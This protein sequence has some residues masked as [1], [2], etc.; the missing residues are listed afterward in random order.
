M[1]ER[2]FTSVG[3]RAA[4]LNGPQIVTGRILYADDVQLPGMLHGA[5]LRSPHGHA[6]I[7]S[8][9]TT[10]AKK[11]PGVVDVVTAKDIPG[12]SIFATKEVTSQGHKIA[13]VAAIDPDI[14]RDAV[15]LIEVDYE[16]LPAVSDPVTGMQPDAPEAVLGA[17]CEDVKAPDGRPYRNVG[18]HAVTEEGDV[19]KAFAE[20]DAVVEF[21]YSAPYW[22][23]AYLEPNS[24]TARLEPDGRLTVWTSCQGSFNIR[25]GLAS[26][27]NMPAGK[28]KVIAVEMGGGFGAKNGMFVEPHAA[29]LAMRT[30]KPVKITMTREEEFHDGR[31]AP[32]CWVRLKTAGK[33]DGT[34]TAMEGRIV[35]DGGIGG[36]GGGPRRL[37]GPYNI[38]NIRLEGF[39]VRTNKPTPGAYRAPGA[40][41][42]ALARES[43]LDA[44][45]KELGLDPIEFRI[46]NAVGKGNYAA[47]GMPVTHDWLPDLLRATAE[48]GKWG[49]R[50]LE[51]NQGI[52]VAVGDWHNASGATNA[53]ITVAADGSVSVLTGQVDITGVHTVMAQIV[54]EELGIPVEK[55]TV[56]LGDTDEV[57]WTSL[58]AGSKATYSAGTAAREAAG[59]A[60]KRILRLASEKLEASPEDLEL[61]DEKVSV[62]GTPE[63]S[64]TLA[65]LAGDAMGT[66][67][68][69][70]SGQWVL[71]RIP[72]YPSYSADIAVVEVDPETGKIKLLDL[73][74]AQDV[75]RALNPMLVEGQM[76]GGAVQSI[77]YGMMEGYAYDEQARVMNPHLLDYAIP[78]IMD[79]PHITSIMVE[80]PAAHGPYG[81]KGVGEPPI[82]PGAAAIVNAVADAIGV[83]VTDIPLT[84]QRIVAALKKAT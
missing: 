16:V 82:I 1:A 78:T 35:W 73:V 45:A 19:E 29:V 65:E 75:G 15:A 4:R 63:Q 3:T 77:A 37:V 44:L 71:G 26:T 7:R 72:T 68:G 25:D 11:L 84:P 36:R 27:L 74:A 13:A 21:E 50:K 9:D 8:I 40:P 49:K 32:G 80:E 70:I 69:P 17:H 6:R 12:I 61:A 46:K 2:T 39:G 10:K 58:S 34:I 59:E 67:E 57:P 18:N 52:G 62:V 38:P 31:P 30:G 56:T 66:N 5:L 42:T 51:K 22:H 54:A 28:I 81:G 24:S 64:V 83:R 33:K 60:R 47:S 20:A 41:Q 55:V 43:N 79:I 76:E 14:A 23:Q 48:K 53:F